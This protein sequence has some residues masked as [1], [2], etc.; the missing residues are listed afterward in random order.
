MSALVIAQ[1][2]L[3][4]TPSSWQVRRCTRR[5]SL[6][7]VL[8][9]DLGFRRQARLPASLTCRHRWT[10]HGMAVPTL[11]R[12]QLAALP[13]VVNAAVAVDAVHVQLRDEA[14]ASKGLRPLPRLK[15]GG[16]YQFG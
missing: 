15:S 12:D 11:A 8:T 4:V 2:A 6:R 13:G 16:P 10:P 5:A 1:A 14:S 9:K 3:T 7:K